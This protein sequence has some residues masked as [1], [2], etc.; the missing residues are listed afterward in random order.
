[1][2]HTHIGYQHTQYGYEEV[3]PDREFGLQEPVRAALEPLASKISL[4]LIYGSVAKRSD[5]AA[6]DIDLLL[7]SDELTLEEIYAAL[8]PV[9]TLLDRWLR[10]MAE[11]EGDIDVDEQLIHALIHNLNA[12]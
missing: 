10:N 4:A 12:A 9:E 5:T 6:S 8:A 11:Y 1:M 2:I 7:V 3:S